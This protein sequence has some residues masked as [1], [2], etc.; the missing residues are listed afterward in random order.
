MTAISPAGLQHGRER[1]WGAGVL[2]TMRWL[3]RN[4]PAPEPLLRNPVTRS[5][6]A[7]PA[8]GAPWRRTR[9]S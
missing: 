4:A 6:L 2:R 9:T 7:G 5:L 1:D 8:V 3:A